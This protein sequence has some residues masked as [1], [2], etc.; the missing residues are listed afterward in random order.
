[1]T[2]KALSISTFPVYKPSILSA[3]R[4]LPPNPLMY[5]SKGEMMSQLYLPIIY[6][7]Q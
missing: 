2:E 4:A 5:V 3:K 7:S 6:S 1:M